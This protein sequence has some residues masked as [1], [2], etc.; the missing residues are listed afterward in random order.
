LI[1]ESAPP[2]TVRVGAH[3]RDALS[4]S[5]LSALDGGPL[6][7]FLRRQRWFGSKGL[8]AATA[9]FRT[10]IPLFSEPIDAAIARVDIM[11]GQ[12]TIA[13]YQ[14]T[15]TVRRGVA[16]HAGVLAVVDSGAGPGILVDA[17]HDA[18]F[19][20]RLVRALR[21]RERFEGQGTRWIAEPCDESLPDPETPSRLLQGEQSNSSMVYGESAVLKIYR[22]LTAGPNPEAEVAEFLAARAFA[23]VPALLGLFRL[24]DADGSET[25]AG[26][27]QQFVAAIGDGWSYARRR[28]RDLVILRHEQ[29][30]GWAAFLDDCRRLGEITGALHRALCSDASN[31]DFSPQPVGADDL[32]RWREGLRRQVD[33]SITLLDASLR[34]G[35]LAREGKSEARVVLTEARAL[36]DRATAFLTG[37]G[38][39][40]G[41][42]IRHHGDYHLGQVLRK[43]DGDYVILDFEGEPARPL[44]ERRQR[45]SPLR[46]VAGML[47]SFAYAATVTVKEDAPTNADVRPFRAQADALATEM[48]RAFRR[49]YFRA[50]PPAPVLPASSEIT[51]GLLTIFEIEKA[52]YELAYELN[53]RPSWVDIPLAGIRELLSRAVLDPPRL[54]Q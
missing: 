3:L 31:P 46:D 20:A 38:P 43:T 13:T 4:L 36:L 48:Q 44:A 5:V 33:T 45:H 30:A 37:L 53:N 1:V 47:R 28:I 12:A 6:I 8:A 29:T 21:D 50:A 19:R 32:A 39:G 17:V 15:L 34:S 40:A 41:A 23:N 18:E 26:I 2:L 11:V 9:R 14:L 42:Q 54:A 10:V 7:E 25:V 51:E 16:N 49:G 22:R 52:F 35:A 24:V 27:A